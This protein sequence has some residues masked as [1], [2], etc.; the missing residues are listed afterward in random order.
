MP[1][2][3]PSRSLAVSGLGKGVAGFDILAHSAIIYG[4]G[5]NLSCWTPLPVVATAAVS[6]LLNPDLILNRG[7]LDSGVHN[8]TQN[9]ILAA[10]EAETGQNFA[11]KHVDEK[12]IKADA[13]E[14]LER[15]D[16]RA[17][18]RGLTI[19][20]NFNEQDSAANFWR[21]V[22]NELVG[23]EA[24]DIREAVRDYLKTCKE[25]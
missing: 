24:V 9:S 5:N 14:A 13:L 1:T 7:I 8:L 11:I 10:L 2:T 6:M 17:A 18:T 19:N 15:K 16:F 12:R 4:T 20:S 3:I 22:E 25:G 23:I 21:L